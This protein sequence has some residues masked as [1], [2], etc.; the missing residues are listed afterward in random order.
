VGDRGREDS[1]KAFYSPDAQIDSF[2]E[3]YSAKG[4][5]FDAAWT[6]AH[7][8]LNRR[9]SKEGTWRKREGIVAALEA[10][11]RGEYTDVAFYK[12][13]RMARNIPDG[14]EIARE[15]SRAGANVHF[16]RD[17]QI[18]DIDTALGEFILSAMLYVARQESENIG[19]HSR[20]AIARKRREGRHHGPLP[21]WV[22]KRSRD[23][24]AAMPKDAP[25]SD[26]Y[27]LSNEADKYKLIASL[28]LRGLSHVKI[29][30]HLNSH[31]FRTKRGNLWSHGEIGHILSPIGI[32]KMAGW[33]YKWTN[34]EVQQR[35]KVRPERVARI[36]PP[37]I[38]DTEAEAL[39]AISKGRNS[40]FYERMAEGKR[41]HGTATG[42]RGKWPC[43]LIVRCSICGAKLKSSRSGTHKGDGLKSLG[44]RGDGSRRTYICSAAKEGHPAH[45]DRGGINV[46]AENLEEAMIRVV[47]TA[48]RPPPQAEYEK[49]PQPSLRP[50]QDRTVEDVESDM[51]M[52]L[53]LLFRKRILPD[54]YDERYDELEKEMKALRK[55]EEEAEEVLSQEALDLIADQSDE[56][57]LWRQQIIIHVAEASYP[58]KWT[59]T[60]KAKNGK[61]VT[62]RCLKVKLKNG[63]EFLAPVYRSHYTG[64][65]V[66]DAVRPEDAEE[67]SEG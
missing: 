20:D 52:L 38:T 62:Y 61:I 32:D 7:Q 19:T 31:G 2:E 39:K 57:A 60:K 51:A 64:D 24:I 8:D 4:I 10:V 15:F 17:Q 34:K 43:A 26:K 5:E 55:A 9:A 35:N 16:V 46:F 63:N 14:L 27:L 12:L 29:A 13:S 18:R 49:S 53:D 41:R 66:L 21:N 50:Q 23:E 67:A 33:A 25:E 1:D 6:R 65:R 44:E 48:L 37:I 59:S 28:G 56:M 42:T 54:H 36:Y 45:K 47:K 30:Q 11:K 40:S 58:H 3:M 22:Q